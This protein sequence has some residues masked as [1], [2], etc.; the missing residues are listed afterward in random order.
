[1]FVRY[2]YTADT[3]QELKRDRYLS[4]HYRFFTREMRIKGY[5]QMLESYQSV[6]L[7]HMAD[8][9]GMTIEHLDR[10]ISRFIA[11]GRLACKIDKVN[12]VIVMSRPDV[13]SRQYQALISKGDNM[14]NKTQKLSRIVNA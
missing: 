12:G 13:K 5:M 1:M 2:A 11:E 10:E 9:F 4:P 7:Q 8:R 3:E 6:R 14:L